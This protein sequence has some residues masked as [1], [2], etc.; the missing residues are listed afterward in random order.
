MAHP[1][2]VDGVRLATARG[3]VPVEQLRQGD[4][5]V[6]LV[7]L[8]RVLQ[9]IRW[10][11]N[12][13]LDLPVNATPRDGA[14]I[15]VR[16]NALGDGVPRRDVLLSH[17]HRLFVGGKL[18][19]AR[20]LVNS[21]TILPEFGLGSVHYFHVELE[22]HTIL[23]AEDLPVESFLDEAGDRSFFTNAVG[24]SVM[25]PILSADLYV[26]VAALACAPLVMTAVESEPAWRLL[27]ERARALGFVP[28]HWET[29]SEPSLHLFADGYK[30][31]PVCQDELRSVFALPV[32]AQSLRLVS[33]AAVPFDLDRTHEDWRCLGVGVTK[34]IYRIGAEQI[35]IRADHPSLIR[36]WHDAETDGATIWRWTNGDAH[37]PLPTPIGAGGATLE[38]HLS[39]RATYAL[40][41]QAAEATRLSA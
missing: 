2:F 11:G 12:R 36:G 32:G 17:D 18:I 9:P 20:L 7:G 16:R 22:H 4:L 25:Q 15:R 28:P 21:M 31:D 3:E 39:G 19:P 5:I 26:D 24:L 10:I 27:A 23:L 14:P 40:M 30:I 37:L 29:T 8:E 38:L 1:C 35:E 13:L 33:R 34:M 6:T 41:D